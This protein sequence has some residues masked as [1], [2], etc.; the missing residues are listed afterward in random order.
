LKKLRDEEKYDDL[1]SLTRAIDN[2][3]KNAR[4]FF[5]DHITA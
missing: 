3:A 4:A 5:A 2:D 1:Q